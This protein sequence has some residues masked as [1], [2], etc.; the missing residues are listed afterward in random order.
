MI[1]ELPQGLISG[2]SRRLAESSAAVASPF[3]GTEQIQDW[4]G[5]WWEYDISIATQFRRDARRLS[6]LFAQLGGKRGRFLMS[7]PSIENPPQS[8]DVVVAG[9][10]QSGTLLDVSGMVEQNL[11]TGDFFQ[12]GTGSETRLH[13]LT[14]DVVVTGGAATLQFVP[15]LRF[16]PIDGAPVEVVNPKVLL[17]LRDS[18][19]ASIALGDK[20]S[21]T[22]TAREAI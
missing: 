14:H 19:P 4:G 10:G 7:D 8:G 20:F 3:T 21:F 2:V 13:Q 22:F 16:V 12:I 5:E 9:A 11:L 6:A 15:A 18:V 1:L 17:R